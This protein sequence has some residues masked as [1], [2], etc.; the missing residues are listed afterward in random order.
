MAFTSSAV[1]YP[2]FIQNPTWQTA[3]RADGQ[4]QRPCY[5]TSGH[6]ASKDSHRNES[7]TLDSHAYGHH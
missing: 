5:H 3:I 4:D 2:L 1:L 6:V 7:S